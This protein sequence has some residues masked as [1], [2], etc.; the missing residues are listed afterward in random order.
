MIN[1]KNWFLG[2]SFIF[3]DVVWLNFVS[4]F[5]F[6]IFIIGF[7]NNPYL[8]LKL[9]VEK[10]RLFDR[11]SRFHGL[12]PDSRFYPISNKS[13]KCWKIIFPDSY[14][15]RQITSKQTNWIDVIANWRNNW[16]QDSTHSSHVGL[17][18]NS[19]GGG[20]C[21]IELV[22]HPSPEAWKPQEPRNEV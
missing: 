8:F 12:W 5:I 9:Q 7:L 18:Q 15:N 13:Q 14:L 10:N 4:S 6:K 19:R 20:Y 11:N 16:L 22:K 21:W 3:W 17:R 1:F 2:K